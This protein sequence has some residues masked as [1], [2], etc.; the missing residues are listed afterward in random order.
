MPAG[1]IFL[2]GEHTSM[3]WQDYMNG[4]IASGQRAVEEISRFFL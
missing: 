3:Q 1:R 2:A 4:V